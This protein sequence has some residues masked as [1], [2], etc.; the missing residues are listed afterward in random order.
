MVRLYE[1]GGLGQLPDRNGVLYWQARLAGTRRGDVLAAGTNSALPP[2]TPAPSPP[3]PPPAPS[4]AL[5]PLKATAVMRPPPTLPPA[6]VATAKPVRTPPRVGKQDL[7]EE[8]IEQGLE[9]YQR[10]EQKLYVGSND[11]RPTVAPYL[12]S[13]RAELKRHLA[14]TMA[15]ATPGNRLIVALSIRRD[16]TVSSV[17]LASGSGQ[18]AQDARVLAALKGLKRLPPLP[19]EIDSRFDLLEVAARLPVE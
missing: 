13:L 7:L 14:T 3:V 17:E 1:E 4:P 2:S 18:P 10:R 11:S 15:R 19:V 5:P 12:K 8:H 9:Q 16:G 6:P